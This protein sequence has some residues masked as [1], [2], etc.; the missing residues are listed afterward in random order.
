MR[1]ADLD[2][3][4]GMSGDMFLGALLDAG[5]APK[6]LE[7]T[8]AALNIGAHLKIERVVRAGVAAT[9]VDVFAYGEKDLPREVYWEHRNIRKN[10]HGSA[11]EHEHRM[12]TS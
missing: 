9:K 7:D 2:C 10:E 1:I 11:H 8:V 6:L 5:V 3:S 4:S 12:S